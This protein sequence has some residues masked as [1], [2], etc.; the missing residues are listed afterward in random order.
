MIRDA[1]LVIRLIPGALRPRTGEVFLNEVRG[2]PETLLRWLETQLG[3]PS[4][5]VHI[6]NRITEYAAALDTVTHGAIT[7]SMQTDRWATASVLLSRRDELLL[8]GWDE[9]DRDALPDIVRD[10]AHAAAGRVFVFPSE[11]HRLKQVLS[12]LDAG[13]TLPPHECALH[14]APDAWP[15]VWRSVLDRLHTVAVPPPGR[16]APAGS[17]LAAAQQFLGSGEKSPLS[18]DVTFRYLRTRSD[19]A[20]IEFLVAALAQAPEKLPTTVICCKDDDL[21]VR[22]DA[23]LL[24]AGLPTTGASNASRA[25]PVLQVLPLALALCRDPVDPQLLLDFLTLP[26][27]PLPRKVRT[28][29]AAALAEEPGLGSSAWDETVAELCTKE[30]DPKGELRARLD[31]WL[32]GER[33]PQSGEIPSRLVRSRCSQ[34]AQWASGRATLLADDPAANPQLIG[35]LRV[36][37]GQ[38]SLLGAL[39]ESQGATISEPQL[40][41]LQEESLADGVETFPYVEATNGPTR[42]HSLAEV[43]AP[44]DRLIWLGLATD[45]ATGC[46]WSTQ[47]LSALRAAGIAVDDGSKSLTALRTAE[48]RGYCYAREA[49]LAVLLPRDLDQRWHPLW[50]TVRCLLPDHDLNAAPVLEDIIAQGDATSLQPFA[51]PCRELPIAP[52]Q[53][54]RALWHIPASLL[55]DRTSVSATELQDRLACPLKWILTYQAKLRAS[56]MAMLPNDFQLRGTF[57]HSILQR[58]F[59]GGEPLPSPD[60]AVAQVLA[61]FDA[62]LPLDAAPLAQPHRYLD[63][64]TLRKELANATRVLIGVLASGRYRIVD[65]EFELTGDAFGKPLVGW[66]DCLAERE[67]GEEAIIDFKYGGRSKYYTLIEEG[68]AVQLA[69]YAYGRSLVTS[70]FP[71]VAYLVL[72]DGLLYTPSQNPISGDGGRSLIDAPAIQQVWEQFSTALGKADVWLTSGVP[73][74]AR[75]QQSPS[76]WPDGATIVL[77]SRLRTDRVQ[78]VCR[79]CDYQRLCGILETV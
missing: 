38:A 5:P 48:I 22:L 19:A 9:A 44:Y 65:I 30:N 64:Q 4:P 12:A 35:A 47:Q 28:L 24:R 23:C 27:S 1:R 75:P 14:D 46:R 62:R 41:R 25:H 67:D 8:A 71:A 33:V 17:A 55:A 54:Q 53:K 39:C 36:A 32:A 42:V 21:A 15:A 51:F 72:S 78:E 3:L 76:D 66:I 16:R 31:A 56:P 74:P 13:Q 73:V 77:D 6:A 63:R 49:S 68:K 60:D 26:I 79:Y 45:D 59:G 10:L 2:G 18:Q 29:L 37:A 34:V 57:C 70:R 40:A 52:V 69:I 58:V 50:L 7:A 61:A 43:D 20:A 11:A